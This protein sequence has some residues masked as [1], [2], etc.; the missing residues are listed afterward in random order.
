[1]FHI[2]SPRADSRIAAKLPHPL[3]RPPS[4]QGRGPRTAGS[5]KLDTI[6]P[7][8]ISWIQN[9]DF[10][11]KDICLLKE[12]HIP[13]QG[14]AYRESDFSPTHNYLSVKSIPLVAEEPDMHILLRQTL[15]KKRQD[16]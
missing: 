6:N 3:R 14:T 7:S 4:A 8:Y 2:Y 9:G 16:N 1:M 10:I 15:L 13:E 5:E 12:A 11:N